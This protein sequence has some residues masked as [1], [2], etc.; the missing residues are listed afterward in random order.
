MVGKGNSWLPLGTDFKSLG[1]CCTSRP[2]AVSWGSGR[3]DIF[4]RGGDSGLWHLSYNNNAGWSNWTSIGST[5]I[6]AEPDAVSWGPGRIDVFAWGAVNRTLLHKSFNGTKW[7]PEDDFDN[8]GG[9]LSGPPKAVC[10]MVGS[11]SVFAYGRHGNLLRKAWNQTQG[12]WL[13]KDSFQDLGSP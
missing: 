6:E 12:Q 7:M 1:G 10:D 13:P 9:D 11:V 3:I 8:L 5:A 4:V 2:V